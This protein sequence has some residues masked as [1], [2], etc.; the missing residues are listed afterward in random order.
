[1]MRRTSD[2]IHLGGFTDPCLIDL[3]G[4]VLLC[5]CVTDS[6]VCRPT[7]LYGQPSWWGEEDYGSKVQSSEEPHPGKVFVI[8][9]KVYVSDH[10]VFT[11]VSVSV[12]CPQRCFVCG[13]RLF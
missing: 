11:D 12:R 13:S 1:M 2:F 3:S 10:L 8:R 4:S 7:P 5:A 6:Q 9:I